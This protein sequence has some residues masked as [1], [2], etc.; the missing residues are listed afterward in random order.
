MTYDAME[1]W[2]ARGKDYHTDE[3]PDELDLITEFMTEH[4]ITSAL[5]VGPGE[6]R[7]YNHLQPG[8]E[9]VMVDIVDSFRDK[10]QKLTGI[11]PDK[12]DGVTLPYQNERFDC[13][14]SVSVLLHV[15]SKDIRQHVSELVRVARRF[16]I[17]CTYDTGTD[18]DIS[19]AGHCFSHDYLKLFSDMGLDCTY[20][21]TRNGFRRFYVI[22]KDVNA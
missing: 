6:G 21:P 2:Q 9:F 16:V 15:P 11:R 3:W 12:W 13:V 5:E 1:Y 7:I 20:T 4:D 14:L 17:I 8:F 10:C 18:Y 22:T 19:G